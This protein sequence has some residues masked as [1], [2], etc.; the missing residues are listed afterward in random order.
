MERTTCEARLELC[1]LTKYGV[2][3]SRSM[4][5][6]YKREIWL[7]PPAV[8]WP[9]ATSEAGSPSA[10]SMTKGSTAAPPA[11]SPP[12]STGEPDVPAVTAKGIVVTSTVPA[13]AAGAG[14][15]LAG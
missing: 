6:V 8:D 13:G 14:V 3:N 1:T 15:S 12:R 5:R 11:V 4:A 7:T 9:Q 10:Y 2:R